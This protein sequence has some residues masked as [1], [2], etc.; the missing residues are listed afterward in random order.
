MQSIYLVGEAVTLDQ[1]YEAIWS[2]IRISSLREALEKLATSDQPV[3][4]T[5]LSSN[6]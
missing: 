2:S 6:T 1:V 5:S 4:P 3:R